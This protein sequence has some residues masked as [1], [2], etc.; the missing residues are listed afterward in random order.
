MS[1]STVIKKLTSCVILSLSQFDENVQLIIRRYEQASSE[2]EKSPAG[3]GRSLKPETP[4]PDCDSNQERAKDRGQDSY[5]TESKN[6][7][8]IVQQT[9]RKHQHPLFFIYYYFCCHQGHQG[10]TSNSFL[11]TLASSS[12]EE[13]EAELQ[14]RVE[15]SQK[16]AHRVVEICEA[17]RRTVDQL[18]TEV[19]SG[20]GEIK[21]GEYG[22]VCIGY[23]FTLLK[24]DVIVAFL[25]RER[26][27]AG[28]H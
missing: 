27:V 8:M 16:Q 18:K 21:E 11:A 19:D 23:V 13:M 17:L 24:C 5:D 7:Q 10:E 9:R 14:V 15:S 4:E 12:S 25:A 22:K 20:T 28:S 1:C 6:V 2:P 26:F 3:E